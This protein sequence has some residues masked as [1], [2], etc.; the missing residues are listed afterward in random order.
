MCKVKVL[1]GGGDILETERSH[2]NK[3]EAREGTRLSCQVN[4]K[5]DMDVEVPEEVFGSKQW[6]CKVRSNES[7]GYFLLRT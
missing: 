2:I 1:D 7:K 4:V 3:R 6:K 5:Q